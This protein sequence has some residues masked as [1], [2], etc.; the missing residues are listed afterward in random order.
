MLTRQQEQHRRALSNIKP[1]IDMKDPRRPKSANGKGARMEEERNA[2]IMHE[3]TILLGK[4]SKILT[5]G[6]P[7]ANPIVAGGEAPFPAKP[8]LHEAFK[9]QEREK[10][11]AE[12]HALLKRLQ[13]MKPTLDAGSFD[14]HFRMHEYHINQTRSLMTANPVLRTALSARRRPRPRS[15]GDVERRM[16][17]VAAPP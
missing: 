13:Y 9:K 2:Q 15:T 10:I 17:P 1:M 12:N 6:S 8:A 7:G 5:R 4:L 14:E 11:N 16:P 3:N